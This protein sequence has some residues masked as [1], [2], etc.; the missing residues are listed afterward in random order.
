[1][2][3]KLDKD[4]EVKCT[5]GTIKDIENRF[6]KPFFTLISGLDKL[7]TSEQIKLL[8]VGVKRANSEITEAQFTE[9]CENNIGLGELTEYL[10]QYIL[11]LQYP[12]LSRE[13]VQQRVEKKLEQTRK[14]QAVSTGTK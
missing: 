11:E 7:T 14:L 4:Y 13:E 5:L 12:G 2:H 3:I 10:E 8:Y 1:M 6:N 9:E